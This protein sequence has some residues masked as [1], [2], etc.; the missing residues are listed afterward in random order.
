MNVKAR[1]GGGVRAI[2]GLMRTVPAGLSSGLCI[3]L[4]GLSGTRTCAHV[5][6]HP[7]T[8]TCTH[9]GGSQEGGG[10]EGENKQAHFSPKPLALGSEGSERLAGRADQAQVPTKTLAGYF[11]AE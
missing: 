6:T 4:C 2:L 10:N 8:H 7:G 3:D 1:V 11:W 5:Y 9:T